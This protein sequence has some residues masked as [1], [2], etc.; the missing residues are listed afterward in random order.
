MNDLLY[1]CCTVTVF[2]HDVN[3]PLLSALADYAQQ[4][5]WVESIERNSITGRIRFVLEGQV[6]LNTGSDDPTGIK[7][8]LLEYEVTAPIKCDWILGSSDGSEESER[9]LY[10]LPER[11]PVEFDALNGMAMLSAELL[12]KADNPSEFEQ[13]ERRIDVHERF[14]QLEHACNLAAKQSIT[15]QGTAT[16]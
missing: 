12:A 3:D 15:Q 16:A 13:L 1:T 6:A 14:V 8:A 9:I 11:E 4:A 2:T 7:K 10:L 5:T